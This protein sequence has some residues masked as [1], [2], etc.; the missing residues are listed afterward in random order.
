MTGRVQAIVESVRK[1]VR[2]L[3]SLDVR[4]L[5]IITLIVVS[6]GH[7]GRLFA[8]REDVRQAFVGYVLALSVDGV[9]AVSLYEVANVRQRSHRVFALFVFLFACAVSAGF[10]VAYYRQSYPLDPPE[11]SLL[12]GITAPIL[13][14]LVSVL[15]SFGDVERTEAEQSERVAEREA[16]HE[17]Y[18]LE[19]VEQT[20]RVQIVEQ[21]RTKRE[22][23]KAR[24]EKARANA[25]ARVKVQSSEHQV[26]HQ[27]EH[28]N[29][30][31]KPGE[32]D[33]LA[34]AIVL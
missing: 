22:R 11:I 15:K 32:R 17:R 23:A 33:E 12:L 24:A 9:L 27:G 10:N 16:E 8:D 21:E 28:S 4:T 2:S 18:K 25:I 6:T 34:R 19:Q 3:R 26:E 13:A 29:G 7:V 14:A 5:L 30:R 1:G 31:L 20:R